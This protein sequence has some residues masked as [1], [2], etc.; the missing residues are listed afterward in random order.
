LLGAGSFSLS[1]TLMALGVAV[2][3]FTLGYAIFRRLN[4]YFEDFL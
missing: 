4:P 1:S 3:V 2:I